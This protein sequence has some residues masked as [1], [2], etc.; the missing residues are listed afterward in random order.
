MGAV[1]MSDT[2]PTKQESEV[3]EDLAT[4]VNAQLKKLDTAMKGDLENF[5]KLAKDANIPAVVVK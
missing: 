2:A 4:K 5:N 1:Q 3:F